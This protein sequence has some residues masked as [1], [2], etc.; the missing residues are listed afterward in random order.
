M[1]RFRED[2]PLI[3]AFEKYEKATRRRQRSL[4]SIPD[5]ISDL[6]HVAALCHVVSPTLM[7]ASIRQH[8][9]E[10]LIDLNGQLN[11]LLLEWMT[12]FHFARS[13]NAS[14]AWFLVAQSAPDFI[15]LIGQLECEV[16]RKGQSE[17]HT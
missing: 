12:V 4:R 3:E 13:Y 17:A 11:P 5:E 7:D 15:T 1:A 14:I 16:D 10:K 9:R 8:H 6:A 2:Q